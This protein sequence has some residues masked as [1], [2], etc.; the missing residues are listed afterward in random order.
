MTLHHALEDLR[1]ADRELEAF[2]AHVL[3]QDG[4]VQF[5]AAGD[6]EHIG[7]GGLLDAQRDVALQFAHQAIADLT[8]GHELALASGERR[9]VDLEGHR[10]R[11]FGDIDRR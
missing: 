8:A 7:V 3:D 5:A 4:Q 2:A 9:G 10:E 1:L 11:R 6:A